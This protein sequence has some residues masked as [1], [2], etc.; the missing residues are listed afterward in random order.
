[1]KRAP[2]AKKVSEQFIYENMES[3]SVVSIFEYDDP[4][5][6]KFYYDEL[7]DK[8]VHGFPL[9]SVFVNEKE[10][11]FPFP[12]YEKLSDKEKEKCRLRFYYLPNYHELYIGTTGSGKTTGCIEPQIRA[13]SSQKNKA[14]LFISDP[15][16]ELF[17][18]NA[19]HLKENGYQL[20]ILNF[21]NLSLSNAWNPLEEMY[22]KQIELLSIGKGLKEVK[23]KPSDDLQKMSEV[24]NNESYF[25]YNN[26]AFN[27]EE[28]AHQYIE[29][30]KYMCHSAATSLVNQFCNCVFSGDVG[31]NDKT[32]VDGARGLMYGI[33]LTMLEEAVKPRS[34][35]TKKMMTLKTVNDI[36][37]MMRDG[38]EDSDVDGL[39]RRLRDYLS[40]KSPEAMNKL[41][42][43]IATA[44]S[45]KKGY[46][47]VFQS[48]V[49]KWMQG[50]IFQLTAETTIN[51]DSDKPWAI[52]IATR[53]YDKS[54]NLIAGLFIDWVYRQALNRFEKAKAEGKKTRAVHFLLDEFAN[55]PKIPDFDNK[56]ATSRSRDIWFHL[57]VQAYDQLDLIYGH[58]TA[59]IIID[60]CNQQA[61]LGSQSIATK[62][63]FSKE[64]GMKT[65]TSLEGT[66]SGQK[67]ALMETRVI[68]ISDLDC[69]IPGE[70]YI[71]RIYSPVMECS[72][73]RSYQCA[74]Y[75]FFKDFY[76]QR[77]FQDLVPINT[78]VP[79][80]EDRIFEKVMPNAYFRMKEEKE[81][82]KRKA[83]LHNK[84][85]KAE[86]GGSDNSKDDELDPDDELQK[87]IDSLLN[88]EEEDD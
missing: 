42:T 46:L 85:P 39:R 44:S 16:G 36:F 15:K 67:S 49:E 38:S 78:I 26:M 8:E 35:F 33:L 45:T 61:F 84:S 48:E 54:D 68:Q 80:A 6:Q 32:W 21:K 40:D 87:L 86:E 73:I 29:I 31:S 70:I 30:E 47:S 10:E 74:N 60:N 23:G 57:F 83:E 18:H 24:F 82:A 50:H 28:E 9:S 52:F 11:V 59:N 63:R 69:I 17:Q 4:Q 71:K 65:V 14:N 53:D 55:I 64:C 12:E 2:F 51:L 3:N 22:D 81:E 5:L 37:A 43:V 27:N 66:L 25:K 77:A 56:I 34:K 88:E 79:D 19:R 72:F 76:D 58:Q 62:E 41:N 7:K 20:F 1:M 13:I 75:G